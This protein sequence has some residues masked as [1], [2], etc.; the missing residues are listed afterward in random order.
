MKLQ[1]MYPF[2]TL[3]SLLSLNAPAAIRYV[4][5]NSATPTPPYTNWVSAATNIQ[6]CR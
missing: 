3:F 2:C 1:Q 5:V 4:D 6:E